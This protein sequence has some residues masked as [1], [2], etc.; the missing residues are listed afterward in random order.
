MRK[1][2]LHNI[3]RGKVVRTTVADVKALCPLDWVNR[4]FTAQRPRTSCGS[5]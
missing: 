1:A 4:K 2:G 3:A 5:A